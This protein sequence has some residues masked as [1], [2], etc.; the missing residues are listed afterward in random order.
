MNETM[1]IQVKTHKTWKSLQLGDE[2]MVQ[3]DEIRTWIGASYSEKLG[4]MKKPGK[5][6]F[7]LHGPATLEKH[8]VAALLGAEMRMPVYSIKLQDAV[9]KLETE[10]ADNLQRI[11]IAIEDSGGILLFDEADALFG[12]RGKIKISGKEFRTSE[13]E[14]VLK[15]I[16]DSPVFIML[17]SNAKVNIND[18]FIRRLRYI[19]NF[20][21]L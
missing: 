6:V 9:S 8:N 16:E 11:F 17:S 1:P 18:P 21:K 7:L 5:Q 2:T 15:L 12:Y 3:L 13:M 19:V 14:R 4:S 10:T 20:P